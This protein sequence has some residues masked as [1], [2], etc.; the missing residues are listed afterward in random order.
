MKKEY[1]I[2]ALS[3]AIVF[4]LNGCASIKDASTA[5]GSTGTGVLAGTVAGAGAGIACD[6]LSGGK[7][8]GA[9]V[10]AGMAV[11][12]LV[13]KLAADLD[14]TAEKS[15]PAMSCDKVK[16]RMQYSSTNTQPQ[17]ALKLAG[18]PTFLVAKGSEFKLPLKLD[19]A[20]PTDSTKVSFTFDIVNGVEHTT[21][22]THTMACGGDYDLPLSIK[23]DAEGVYNGTVKLINADGKPI[24]G[25][26]ITYCYTVGTVNQCTTE[27]SK[28]TEASPKKQ[29][30]KKSKRKKANN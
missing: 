7:M 23:S 22:N 18:G 25:A 8:T 1:K 24:D 13:G 2:V 4:L 27:A 12:A 26:I 15:V 20:T 28:T 16:S 30:V 3:T 5:L 19:I 9:C 10:A 11:G 17:V 6:K 14:E 29:S 21:S